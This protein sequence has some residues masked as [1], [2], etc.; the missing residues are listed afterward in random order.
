MLCVNRAQLSLFCWNS[1]SMPTPLKVRAP[2]PDTIARLVKPLA[3]K[4]AVE[5]FGSKKG[6]RFKP[7]NAPSARRCDGMAP[8]RNVAIAVLKQV[9]FGLVGWTSPGWPVDKAK[10]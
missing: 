5:K 10:F 4:G 3:V 2:A 9:P 8:A 7:A 6:F 1:S